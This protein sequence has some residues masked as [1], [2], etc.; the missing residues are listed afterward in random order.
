M[1]I[2]DS[3]NLVGACDGAAGGAIFNVYFGAVWGGGIAVTAADDTARLLAAGFNSAAEG[4]VGD[5]TAAHGVVAGTE[6][7]AHIIC[8]IHRGVADTVIDSAMDAAGD[9]ADHG[10]IFVVADHH[11]FFNGAVAD[12]N[13][14]SLSLIHI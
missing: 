2:R 1:C 5:R 11:I 14:E 6:N 13:I 8:A 9:G 4:T 7:A 10:L 12:G 3:A